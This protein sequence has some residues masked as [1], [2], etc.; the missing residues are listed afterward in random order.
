MLDVND[1]KKI[2]DSLGHI[3]GDEALWETADIL[4]RTLGKEKSFLARYGGDEFAVIGEWSD[5][6]E[7][8]AAITAVEDEVERFNKEAGKAYKLSFSIGYAMWNEADN[9]EQLVKKADERMYLVKARKKS[10]AAKHI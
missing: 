5:G 10:E 3:V 6:Q 8:R 7:A 2:N 1:F 4:R 9:I